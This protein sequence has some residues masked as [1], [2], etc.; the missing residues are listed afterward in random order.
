MSP[1]GTERWIGER[2]GREMMGKGGEGKD[3]MSRQKPH[4][5]PPTQAGAS[6]QKASLGCEKPHML[7]LSVLGPGTEWAHI[8]PPK[9]EKV[10]PRKGK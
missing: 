2:P 7:G 10:R 1:G 3:A 9:M 5:N 4:G 6:V 8:P